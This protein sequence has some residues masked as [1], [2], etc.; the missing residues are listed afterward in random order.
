M[1]AVT[2]ASAFT[3]SPVW[4]SLETGLSGVADSYVLRDGLVPASAPRPTQRTTVRHT[5][6]SPTDV[7]F[8]RD[9]N[10]WCPFCERV[11]LYLLESDVSTQH[12]FVDLGAKQD[13]YK[14]VIP[15]GQTPSL[16]LGGK[17]VWESV[18]IM[19][20]LER[21]ITSGDVGGT[22]LLPL[23]EPAR[24][25]VLEELTCFDSADKGGL[26]IGAAGYTYMR[27]AKFGETP[28]EGGANLAELRTDFIEALEALE[29]RLSKAPGPWFEEE[30]GILDVALWPSIERQVAGLPAFRGFELRGNEQFPA[31]A[32]WLEAMAARPAVRE[33]SSDDGT[34]VR[35][36]GRVF[37]MKGGTPP[38]DAV[39]EFGGEAAREAASKLVRNRAAVAAD[40]LQ[41]AALAGA[42]PE[43]S[44]L[45]Y[46]DAALSLVACRLAA[47]PSATPTVPDEEKSAAAAV[48]SAALAFLRTRVSSPRDMSAA[49]AAQLR[50]A[51]ALEAASAYD[52]LGYN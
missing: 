39:A 9:T 31:V 44:T 45:A 1:F 24:S 18:E 35:L 3:V 20:S 40:I 8:Y 4:K 16:S 12:A 5:E 22:S 17:P 34:L 36:F 29:V 11:W 25:R 27:G 13:W 32:A 26:R 37:G 33:V 52:R 6:V 51:C 42:L 28:P 14:E 43:E 10:A 7:V 41:H 30:F 23:E 21:A 46:V 47:E 50:T 19:A 15:T 38:A 48:I 49:A 2:A